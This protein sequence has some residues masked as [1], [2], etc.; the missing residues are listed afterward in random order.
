MSDVD[1]DATELNGGGTQN[2]SRTMTYP[3]VSQVWMVTRLGILI[4]VALV[5]LVGWLSYRSHVSHREAERRDLL[6][7][8]GKQAALNLT[9]INWQ[10][11]DADI[12]R[13]LDGATSTFY[14]DFAKRSQPFVSVVKEAKSKSVGTITAAGLES[15]TPHAAEVLVAVSVK[16]STADGPEQDPRS[17]R[18][19]ISVQQVGDQAKVSRVEFVP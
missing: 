18:M 3:G 1:E 4:V 12:Q 17:W 14:D 6:L 7:Q 19:R 9:T 5:G 2:G 10:E 16:T 11:A 8:V 13:I 15:Q